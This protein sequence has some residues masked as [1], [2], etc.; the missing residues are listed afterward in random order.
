MHKIIFFIGFYLTTVLV[1]GAEV[2]TVLTTSKSMNK[3]IKAVVIRPT[4]DGEKKEMP[5]V[6]LLHG[7]SGNYADW[8][9]KVPAIKR[10]ADQYQFIIVCPDG[11]FSSWYFDSPIDDNFKYE[12]YIVDELIPFID[13]KYKTIK[14]REGRA[15][16][17]LSMG[18]HGALYL[19][20]KHQDLFGAAGS[21]SGGVD[22][23]PFPSNWDLAKRL[24]MQ[25]EHADLWEKYTVTNMLHLLIPNRLSIIIDCGTGDF[26]YKVNEQLHHKLLDRN[27]P[28]DYI[29]RAGVHNWDYWANSIQYQ[30]LFMHRFFVAE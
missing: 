29:T 22:I 25:A 19:S 3:A 16:T 4:N 24:G 1:H 9:K 15:I 6:Y 18:G 28:H 30:L 5:V 10:L 27:I 14:S 23:R 11:G 20:F 21:M 7:Y 12:T 26:F 8:I 13:Q 2:D 17:G